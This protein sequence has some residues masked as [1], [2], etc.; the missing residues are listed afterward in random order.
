MYQIGGYIAALT[1][2]FMWSISSTIFTT[3]GNRIGPLNLNA[4]RIAISVFLFSISNFIIYG[5]FFP[6]ASYN[7]IAILSLSGIIG[8]AVGD[9]AYFGALIEIGPRKAILVSSTAPIFSLIGGFYL[10]GEVPSYLALIGIFLVLFGIWIV[11]VEK[12]EKERKLKNHVVKGTIFGTIAALGQGIGVVLSKYGMFCSS[13]P[14]EPLPTTV[15]RVF[16][17]LPVIWLTLILW[18]KPKH[19]LVGLKD[20]YALKLV[21]IGSF[22]GPFIGLWLSMIAIKYAQVGIASTLLSTTPIMI[23]PVV[24]IAYREKINLRGIFGALIAVIG[25]ALIFLF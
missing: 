9:L 3:V 8:L 18:K 4:L 21:V 19:I 16:A 25:I 15:I 7:Q 5:A 17:A 24:Y 23:I 11:I 22:I 20:K 14:L 13:I 1:A 6:E 2:A 12:R 10:L